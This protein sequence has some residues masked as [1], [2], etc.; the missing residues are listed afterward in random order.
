[1][2]ARRITI[3]I[4][5]Y[6]SSITLIFTIF[7][8]KNIFGG[9]SRP[10]CQAHIFFYLFCNFIQSSISLF[11]IQIEEFQIK[12]KIISIICEI[13]GNFFIT[14]VVFVLQ[15]RSQFFAEMTSFGL[16]FFPSNFIYF[17]SFPRYTL[18]YYQEFV[19]DIEYIAMISKVCFGVFFS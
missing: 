15:M 10:I 12:L 5:C 7:L 6:F 3:Y 14:S 18:Q 17:N 16:Y 19:V 2:G 9:K 13:L 8:F 1:M 4:I 11:V